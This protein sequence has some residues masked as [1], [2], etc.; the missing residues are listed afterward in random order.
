[1]KTIEIDE[2]IYA[3]IAS[4]TQEIG[5]TASDILRRLLGFVSGGFS[6]AKQVKASHEL[7]EIL[8]N[9]KLRF[10]ISAVDKFLFILSEASKQRPR[11]FEKVLTIQ[12][13]NRLYF[14]KSRNEIE[15]SGNS[16]QPKQ[17][18]GTEYWVMTNSPTPQKVQMLRDA[19]IAIG[20]SDEAARSAAKLIR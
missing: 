9:P 18:P 12:G 13:R 11:D 17:I 3:Y 1:M 7:Q 2:D 20:Y 8:E 15:S 5:E 4:N 19:L 10:Q 16:T 14:A 6:E